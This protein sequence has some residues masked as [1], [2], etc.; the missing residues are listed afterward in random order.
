MTI[1]R[2]DEGLIVTEGGMGGGKTEESIRH[3]HFF[4]HTQ[5]LMVLVVQPDGSVREGIDR[6]GEAGSRSGLCID[7]SRIPTNN[8]YVSVHLARQLDVDV[9]TYLDTHMFEPGPL[10]GAVFANKKEGRTSLV[11]T[12][13]FT[14]GG[15][16]YRIAEVLGPRADIRLPPKYARCGCQTAKGESPKGKYSQLLIKTPFRKREELLRL[17]E[18]EDNIEMRLLVE[19]GIEDP[20]TGLILPA[21]AGPRNITGNITDTSGNVEGI[22]ADCDYQP[23]C[24]ECFVKPYKLDQF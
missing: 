14:Y 6:G 23:R 8:A 7:V 16:A 17:L 3:S 19:H 12:L 10:I 15:E 21:Y 22:S 9:V 2:G 18:G 5:G 4:R 24:S 11:D 1:L 20:K 13:S